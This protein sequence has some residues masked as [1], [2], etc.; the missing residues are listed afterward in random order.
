MFILRS[1]TVNIKTLCEK[2][3]MRACLGPGVDVLSAFI[4][5]AFS[6]TKPQRQV[7]YQH[8]DTHKHKHTH[9]Q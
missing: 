4:S 9:K 2:F 7:R 1:H 8:K 3:S 5:L 6:L